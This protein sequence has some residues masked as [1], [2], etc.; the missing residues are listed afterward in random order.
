MEMDDF[1]WDD[2]E[3][4]EISSAGTSGVEICNIQYSDEYK[5]VMGYL[6]KLMSLKEYSE[7]ALILTDQVIKL[8]PAHYTIWQYR[9]DII[10]FLK[11]DILK[12][13]EWCE[14]VALENQKN[15]QIWH[16]RQLLIELYINNNGKFKPEFEYPLIDTMIGEDN[17]NYH[18]WAYRKWLVEKF[19]LYADQREIFFINEM[20]TKDIR[21]NSA[22]NHRFFIFFNNNNKEITKNLIK[23]EIEFTKN[24]I[25]LAPQNPS[26]WNYLLGIY[27]N[28]KFNLNL[29]DLEPFL[30]KYSNIEEELNDGKIEPLIISTFS[31]EI[32]AKIYQLNNLSEKSIKI[33]NLLADKYDPIRKNY[34]HYKRD[35]LISI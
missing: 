12:E 31:L 13:L 20:L 19:N 28:E 3:P 35:N 34:W 24:A 2:I 10:K 32:L 7:R 11:K 21:N 33:Y 1:S 14:R 8:V 30:L 25:D 6:I 4:C 27:E 22:W 5:L 16:Y 23:Q 15:Y 17:K 9:F 26:P 29:K 18:V